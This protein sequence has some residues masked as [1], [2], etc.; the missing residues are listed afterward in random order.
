MKH[1]NRPDGEA[2]IGSST[3][4]AAAPIY[5]GVAKNLNDRL[6]QHTEQLFKLAELIRKNPENKRKLLESDKS[7]FASRAL[8]TGFNEDTVVVWTL[9]LDSLFQ[10]VERED[11]RAVAESAEWLL[12]RWHKPLLGKR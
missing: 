10:G 6:R 2:P 12:N 4:F 8:A 1:P 3:P 9:N 7:T 5:V 11:L